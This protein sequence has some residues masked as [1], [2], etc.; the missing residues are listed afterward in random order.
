[1]SLWKDFHIGKYVL[2]IATHVAKVY[3]I[4]NKIGKVRDKFDQDQCIQTKP[5]ML[6]S[7]LSSWDIE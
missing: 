2:M 1:M 7:S 4:M 5:M 3:V 6:K